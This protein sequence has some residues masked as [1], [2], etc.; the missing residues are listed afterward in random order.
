MQKILYFS[1]IIS[2][3]SCTSVED[4]ADA[5]G[6]FEAEEVIISSQVAGEVSEMFVEE[7]DI[8]GQG[9]YILQVDTTSL[10][11]QKGQV[12]SSIE[13]LKHKLQDI[14]TQLSVYYER[15]SNLEKEVLRIG[16]LLEKGAATQKQFDDLEGELQVVNRQI[17]AM[18]SQLSTSNRGI[19]AEIEPLQWKI[20]QIDHQIGLSRVDAPISGT[21][22][23]TYIEKGEMASPGKPLVKLADLEEMI[24]RAYVSGNQ[25]S[26]IALRQR[27]K[28]IA[29]GTEVKEGEIVWI[30]S[31]AEFTPK[32]I[33]TK[34][35]RIN[36][37]YAVKVKVKNSSGNF[38]I[39]MP[40]EIKFR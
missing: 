28:V 10:Y 29:D 1:L 13:A 3:L 22:I 32:A 7:G 23:S 11:L 6:N 16:T 40:G 2:F 35:E 18:K 14:P 38:K 21:V 39:G 24:L 8:V 19:L 5:Y 9:E 30:A 33:Q 12:R 36:Q 34:E 4:E 15:K 27:V 37:V 26:E 20:R 25:L 31:S 17:A